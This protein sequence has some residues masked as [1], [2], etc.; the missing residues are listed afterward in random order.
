MRDY[1]TTPVLTRM[2]AMQ[3]AMLPDT[4]TIKRPSKAK[5]ASGSTVDTYA[6]A[7]T[8]VKCEVKGRVLREITERD[9]GGANR[10]SVRWLVVFAYDTDVRLDDQLWVTPKGT[11]QIQKFNVVGLLSKESWDTATGVECNLVA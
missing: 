1:L 4:C 6:D 7:A 8:G 10:S 9:M 3:A 11:T 5:T 2:R